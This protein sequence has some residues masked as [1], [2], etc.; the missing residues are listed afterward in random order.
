MKVAE[1][2]FEYEP[3]RRTILIYV[4]PHKPGKERNYYLYFNQIAVTSFV[5]QYLIHLIPLFHCFFVNY[6]IMLLL[7]I[8]SN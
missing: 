3:E 8:V 1:E 5:T 6:K 2:K 7:I 4:D